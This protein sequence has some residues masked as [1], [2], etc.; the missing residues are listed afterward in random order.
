MAVSLFPGWC[1]LGSS[2]CSCPHTSL[3]KNNT[4]VE[5]WIRYGPTAGLGLQSSSIIYFCKFPPGSRPKKK[6][7]KRPSSGNKPSGKKKQKES[8]RNPPP[9]CRSFVNVGTFRSLCFFRFGAV[10]FLNCNDYFTH[11]QIL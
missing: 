5:F 6:K 11:L 8:P 2:C 9:S 10:C 3:N 7:K 4:N 1:F